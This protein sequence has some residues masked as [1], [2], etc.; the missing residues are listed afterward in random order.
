[1]AVETEEVMEKFGL[2]SGKRSVTDKSSHGC[3]KSP[4]SK[5]ISQSNPN[6]EEGEEEDGEIPCS[7][8]PMVRQR[9]QQQQQQSS[10]F[11]SE[12]PLSTTLVTCH[13]NF[14]GVHP[15]EIQSHSPATSGTERKW[16][17]SF[18]IYMRSKKELYALWC[19]FFFFFFFGFICIWKKLNN[20]KKKHMYICI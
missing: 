2:Y 1:V 10:S 8:N 12:P 6:N 7:S 19:F 11:S 4:I 13:S 17:I 14:S 5:I 18:I 3:E 20:T 16:N 15:T 9:S